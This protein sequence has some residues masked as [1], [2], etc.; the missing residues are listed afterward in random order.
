M[1]WAPAMLA[2]LP[3]ALSVAFKPGKSP[4]LVPPFRFS[5]SFGLEAEVEAVGRLEAGL[6]LSRDVVG[7]AE[8]IQEGAEERGFGVLGSQ[9][10]GLRMKFCLST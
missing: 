4:R 5:F 6:H 8:E 2:S 9:L 7:C 1:T 10:V 3:L